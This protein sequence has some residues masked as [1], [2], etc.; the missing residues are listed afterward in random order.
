VAARTGR[1]EFECKAEN[2]RVTGVVA[3]ALLIEGLSS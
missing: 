3:V 1:R 2:T